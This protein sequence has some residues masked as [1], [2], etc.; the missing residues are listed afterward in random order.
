MTVTHAFPVFAVRDLDEAVRYYCD[1]LGFAEAWRFGEPAHRAGVKL[2]QVEIHLD[3]GGLG[4]TP[5]HSIVYCH[6]TGIDEHY[7]NCRQRGARLSRELAVRPWGVRDFQV[8][9]PC[10][11]K[12]GFAE[13]L[14]R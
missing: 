14:S 1:V 7:R 6:M 13:L 12:I 3:A 8:E 5:G 2:D 10:G 9:D 4:A 11:N